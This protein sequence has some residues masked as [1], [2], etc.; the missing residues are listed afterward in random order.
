MIK[1]N[2]A[3]KKSRRSYQESQTQTYSSSVVMDSN[4][5]IQKQGLKR[6]I[7]LCL[8]PGLMF[9]WE[10]FFLPS[11][12]EILTQKISYRD[13]IR[14]ENQKSKKD[15]DEIKK[16]EEE[17]KKL[18]SE[19]AAINQLSKDRYREVRI[20]E[21]IQL[22]KTEKLSLTRLEISENKLILKGLAMNDQEISSFHENLQKSVYFKEITPGVTREKM[23]E[24]GVFKEFEMNLVLE[25]T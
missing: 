13:K 20:M 15:V 12:Q 19:I 7:V 9:A 3:K 16:Y 17:E 4:I 5:D 14:S 6:L 21:T 11:R 25:G 22:S 10:Y 18:N 1:V 24:F 8:V 23:T 2:L